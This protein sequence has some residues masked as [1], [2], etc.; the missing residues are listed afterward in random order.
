MVHKNLKDG[1]E[2]LGHTVILTSNG[3]YWKK[4]PGSDLPMTPN[5]SISNQKMRAVYDRFLQPYH[6]ILY[7]FRLCVKHRFDV[8]HI[9]SA[10]LFDYRHRKRIYRFFR[11]L[12]H[13]R[14]YVTIPGADCYLYKAWKYG[15]F[16]YASF[17]DNP[18]QYQRFDES[19][20]R[21]VTENEAYRYTIEHARILIPVNPYETEIPFIAFQSLRKLIPLPINTDSIKYA[22]NTV[23]GKIIIYHGVSYPGNKGSDYILEAFDIIKE[24]YGNSVEIVTTHQL[25]YDEF[26]EKLKECNIYVDQ[27]KSYNYG[28]S[29]IISMAMGKIVLSGNAPEIQASFNGHLCPIINI[30][31]DARQIASELDKLICA[32]ETFKIIG[33]AGRTFVEEY[34]NCRE[35]AKMYIKEWSKNR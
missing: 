14:L 30:T 10:D 13:N 5:V 15:M 17:D 4:I 31:P 35:I 22:D 20:A 25:P 6:I 29:A 16:R 27:C 3:D 32:K 23:N 24:K 18:E 1:L 9:M 28:M 8:I 2:Q 12:S 7:Y 33:L 26:I 11:F 21:S 19:N 34:H